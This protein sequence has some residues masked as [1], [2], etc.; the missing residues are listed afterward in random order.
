MNIDESGHLERIAA[1]NQSR[2]PGE[3]DA[4]PWM[5]AEAKG[6]AADANALDAAGCVSIRAE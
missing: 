6:H 5:A 3:Q 1:S 4:A 2:G